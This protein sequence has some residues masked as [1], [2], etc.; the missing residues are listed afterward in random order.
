MSSSKLAP[1][2]KEGSLG[3]PWGLHEVCEKIGEDSK[4]G[5][6]FEGR[7]PIGL[8]ADRVYARAKV[9]KFN[10]KPNF[11]TGWFGARGKSWW[12]G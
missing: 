11:E 6:V 10:N 8:T 4:P 1:S 5:T 3:T 9:S 2:C 12:G 7:V